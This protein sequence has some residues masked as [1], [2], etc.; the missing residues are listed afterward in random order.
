SLISQ[1]KTAKSESEQ[2]SLTQAVAK[3][4]QEEVDIASFRQPHWLLYQFENN[5]I[6]RANQRELI[7]NMLNQ[8]AKAMYQL[9]MGEGKSSVILPLLS[10]NVADGERVLRINVLPALLDTMKNFLRQRLSGLIRK[11]VYGL[12]FY[13]DTDISTENL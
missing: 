8:D 11:R 5:I 4:L 7:E 3:T 9:N 12:P 10:Y 13:R 6:V 1:F 2:Y